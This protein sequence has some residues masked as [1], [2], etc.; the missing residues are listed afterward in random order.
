MKSENKIVTAYLLP[1]MAQIV[2]VAILA[3]VLKNI[4]IELGYSSIP[5][6]IL[7]AVGGISSALWGALYQCRYNEKTLRQ[8]VV[9]FFSVRQPVKVYLLA[10][11]FLFIDFLSVA[12]SREFQVANVWIPIILFLKAI[13]VGGI[14][15]IGWRYTFQPAIE[16]KI[17]Y[18]L[19]TVRTFVTWG[20]WHV[21]F[22]YIDGTL[23]G[24]NSVKLAF[25]MLGLLTNCF[26]LSCL[27]NVSGSLWICVMT[28]ALINMGSQLTVADNTVI[29]I[30]TKII[31]VG[32]AII[33]V[34]RG[35]E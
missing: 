3:V 23:P 9:D 11:V 26:I 4:G 35:N 16:S 12:V 30:V 21:L 14:E 13:L 32:I 17:P 28:H 5:G 1:T 19:A 10:V 2:A 15:E 22:F 25:F 7:I 24:L 27:F 8:I 29:G 20:I 31:C 18:V 6:I 34:K 33:I